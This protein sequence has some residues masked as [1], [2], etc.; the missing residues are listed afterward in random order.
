MTFDLICG[1]EAGIY[2]C[3]SCFCTVHAK[4]DISRVVEA[5]L[6][7]KFMLFRRNNYCHIFLG[8][9][10]AGENNNNSITF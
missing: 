6:P 7:A 9:V 2:C 3:C 10:M 1:L 4:H 5:N 8:K